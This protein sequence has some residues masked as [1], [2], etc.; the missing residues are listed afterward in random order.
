MKK[1]MVKVVKNN[2]IQ[3]FYA[4]VTCTMYDGLNKEFS[5]ERISSN[6]NICSV[7][8]FTGTFTF[9]SKSVHYES[10]NTCLNF[11]FMSLPEC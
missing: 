4:C 9:S 8:Y 1:K 10:K 6:M 3:G 2:K 7:L 5:D 11:I